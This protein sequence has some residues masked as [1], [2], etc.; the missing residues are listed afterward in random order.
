MR[1]LRRVLTLLVIFVAFY[2]GA[3]YWIRWRNTVTDDVTKISRLVE[4]EPN[5]M[6][7]LK[8]VRE[9]GGK[10][11]EL[12]FERVDQP[13]PGLTPAMQFARS[14][15]KYV[16]PFEGE[17]DPVALRRVA[18]VICELYDPV[19]MRK[20]DAQGGPGADGARA[21]TASFSGPGG[22]LDVAFEFGPL[23]GGGRSSAIRFQGGGSER[24]VGIPSQ[25]FQAASLAPEAY[26]NYRVMR[27]EGDNVQVVSLAVD[28]KERFSLERNGADW[29][30]LAGGKQRPGSEA[31]GR[32]LNRLASLRAI[33]IEDPAYSPERC[34]QDKARAVVGLR[35]VAGREETLR[36]SYGKTGNMVACSTDRSTKFL[37]HRD[38]LK[39]L[40]V[41]AASVTAQKR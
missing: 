2:M 6:R 3:H 26:R 19:P 17:A 29:S 27:V 32:F 33:G 40:D 11:E 9:V 14:E 37:V 16:S 35:A 13:E 28:G 22:A 36:F 31:A 38:L 41:S 20:E 10:A 5:G 23:S 15:W 4:C 1:V 34:A 12:R 30:V 39:F 18:S 25:L 24:T 8:L 7:R 21:L